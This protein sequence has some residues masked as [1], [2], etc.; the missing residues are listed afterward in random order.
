MGLHLINI[1]KDETYLFVL[2]IA[3][4]GTAPKFIQNYLW[5]NIDTKISIAYILEN[6][7]ILMYNTKHLFTY[8]IN[9]EAI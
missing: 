7:N 6:H 4:K 5:I 3:I 8:M 9:T 1:N 2:M